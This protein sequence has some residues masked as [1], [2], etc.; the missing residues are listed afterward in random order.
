MRTPEKKT[1]G[2][3]VYQVTPLPAGKGLAVMAR[4]ARILG[5]AL[6]E[7][8]SLASLATS[9]PAMLGK[10][11]E[12]VSEADVTALCAAFAE[13]T[14]V[15]DGQTMV[16]LARCFDMHFQGDYLA[17]WDWLRLCFEVNFAPLFD[18]LAGA[19]AGP[20]AGSPATAP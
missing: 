19:L 5:P 13:Y 6:G 17:L 20:P 3:K 11:L 18:G 14:Q 7:V 15:G 1:I 2:T 4:C 8:P 9:G 12:R 16:S 10:L